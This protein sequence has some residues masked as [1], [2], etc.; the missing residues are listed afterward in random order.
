MNLKYFRLKTTESSRP[1]AKNMNFQPP[2]TPYFE[3][4][5]SK[6]SETSHPEQKPPNTLHWNFWVTDP[7]GDQVSQTLKIDC[8]CL[9]LKPQDT[10]HEC[11][12]RPYNSSK[13]PNTSD[14]N[15]EKHTYWFQRPWINHVFYFLYSY[16]LTSGALLSLEGLPLP[17][18]VKS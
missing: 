1:Q 6:S 3:H 16:D 10:D 18:L 13:T 11:I 7:R 8:K 14:S 4:R 15:T 5:P 12:Q 9:R 2:Q 17:G